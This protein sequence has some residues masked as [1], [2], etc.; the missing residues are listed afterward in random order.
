VKTIL[1]VDNDL[2]FVF[3]LGQILDLAGYEAYPAKSAHDATL[4]MAQFRPLVNL[5]I[6]NS[7]LDGAADFVAGLRQAQPEAKIM[8]IS[9]AGES[10]PYELPGTDAVYEKMDWVDQSAKNMWVE[11]VERTLLGHKIEKMCGNP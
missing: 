4:F 11:R 2:G 1:V 8:A 6:I 7:A 10:E 9:G 5:L 3:W